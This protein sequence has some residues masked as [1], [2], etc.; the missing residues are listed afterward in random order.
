MQRAVPVLFTALVLLA[1]AYVLVHAER[2]AAAP[3]VAQSALSGETV[4]AASGL[5]LGPAGSGTASGE[6]K[7]DPP[8][9][10]ELERVLQ[11]G[12][13]PP[14]PNSAPESVD[15]AVILFT[16]QDAQFASKRARDKSDALRLAKEVLP[17]ARE[18]FAE[19]VKKGD[20][21]STNDAGSVPRGV[22][23]PALQY[24]VYT[25]EKDQV[26]P[27]PVDTPRGY[28]IVKRTR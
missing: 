1:I 5:A 9:E 23:E 4:P 20:P 8:S 26:F 22:L 3:L 14:L 28:W 24:L 10:S 16:H 6:S 17:E 25:L 2:P 27:E 12:V 19:A 18:N 13:V 15:I 7:V 11:G 21:G